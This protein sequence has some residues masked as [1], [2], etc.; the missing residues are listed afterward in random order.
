MQTVAA[1]P[2]YGRLRSNGQAN[3]KMAIA[4]KTRKILWGR[5]GNRCAICKT[6]LVLEKDPFNRNLNIGEECHIISKKEN[7]PRHEK[8][9]GFDY[10]ESD[11]L[12]LLCCNHHTMIDEQIEKFTINE[13]RR[14]KS[15]HEAWVKSNLEQE[16]DFQAKE[17]TIIENLINYISA[18]HD[19]EMNLKS[20]RNI[21]NSNEG[22]QIAFDEIEKIKRLIYET[23]DKL[24][25]AAPTYNIVKRDNKQHITDLGGVREKYGN[26]ALKRI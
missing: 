18:K 9:D 4:V 20:S 14:I 1:E 5:S 10:D 25:V 17:K 12:L 24:N 3:K 26:L 11:N 23:V 19:K 6:E 16:V 21:I 8:L 7:G 2:P 13:L 22:L 15:E